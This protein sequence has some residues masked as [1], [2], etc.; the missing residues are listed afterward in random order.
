MENSID[1]M[2]Q[3]FYFTDISET[4]EL[5]VDTDD[6]EHIDG[7]SEP[8]IQR[9]P[10]ENEIKYDAEPVILTDRK[11]SRVDMMNLILAEIDARKIAGH[12]INTANWFY[13]NG[14]NQIA[15]NI[16]MI[17]GRIK[18]YRDKVAE[19]LSIDFINFEVT[20]E[21]I[22][23]TPATR[24]KYSSSTSTLLTPSVA[25]TRSMTY[26]ANMFMN[27]T[28]TAIATLKN[29]STQTRTEKI[30]DHRIAS[31]PCLVRSNLCNTS[32]C[33]TEML[34]GLNEDPKDPGGYFII[35]GNEWI[36]DN[37][38]NITTNSFHVYRNMH[39]NEITRGTFL[40]KPGDAFENS[41]QIILRYLNTGAITFELTKGKFDKIELPFYLI[42]R[43]LGITSDKKIVDHIVLG[44][45]NNDVITVQL[46]EIII[47]AFTTDDSRFGKLMQ[48]IDPNKIIQELALKL[49]EV[50]IN[51]ALKDDNMI[52]HL[53]INML[54]LLDKFIFPHI[55][56]TREFRIRKARFLGH[57]INKLLLVTLGIIEPTDRNSYAN[58]R[59]HSAGITLAKSFKTN[60]NL[61][62]VQPI[63]NN[64]KKEF[65]ST[66]FSQ[67]PL[68][69]S[70]K[71]SIKGDE[72]ERMM[73]H[74]IT[75]GD[76]TITIRQTE[77]VNRVSSQQMH[78][79]N[80]LN[81]SS[82]LNGVNTPG[83]S[84]SK[85]NEQADQMRRVQ[86]SYFGFIDMSQ[87]ADG[88]EK[89]GR[90]KQLACT[91]SISPPIKMYPLKDRLYHDPDIINI[92][93]IDP[94][95]ITY[96]K[97]AK[98][99]VN[100]DWIGCCKYAKQIVDKYRTH[101]RHGTIHRY[102]TIVWNPTIRE[103]YFWTDIGRLMRP[104]TIVYN[105]INDYIT[106][107]RSGEPIK[108]QQW[109]KLTKE[110]VNKLRNG[111]IDM[112]YLLNERI[113]EYIS[114]EEQ[115]NML[116]AQSIDYLRENEFNILMPYT[117][118]DIEQAMF[119]IVTLACPL[120]N[121]SSPAR[122]TMYTNHRKQSAS[123][124]ALNWDSLILKS[125]TL[126]WY[127]ENPPVSTIVNNITMPAGHTAIVAMGNFGNNQED[128]LIVNGSSIASGMFNAT[129]YD[130]EKIELDKNEVFGN[131]DEART[132]RR[133]SD[134]IYEYATDGGLIKAG[135][136][137]TNGVVLAIK[138]ATLSKPEG[139]YLYEDRSIVYSKQEAARVDRVI[140]VRDGDNNKIVKIVLASTRPL[141]VGDK[142]SSRSGNKGICSQIEQRINM[143]YTEDGLVP[144]ILCNTHS[145]PT[146]MAVN[147]MIEM[148][149]DLLGAHYGS[150]IDGTTFKE[151]DI[152]SA[153]KFLADV[154]IKYAGTRTMYSGTTGNFYNIPIF[155]A[156][157]GYQRLQ[158]Y[159]ID[160][161]YANNSGPIMP[162]TH[163]PREGKKKKGGLKFGEMEKDVQVA[164]GTM[165]AF[166]E[167]MYK[168]SDIQ[169]LPFCRK[170]NNY[171]IVNEYAN[172]YKCLHCK[173]LADIVYVQ[174]SH[175]SKVLNDEFVSMNANLQYYVANRQYD[176]GEDDI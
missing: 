137:V 67:V 98:V 6:S 105:N 21:N 134:A 79:K 93:D 126:Q 127:C 92:D 169:F 155:I 112:E 123:W 12:H 135:T 147:Q 65:A 11:V 106:K 10:Q 55:G 125:V 56:I 157:C 28:V 29:G 131:P 101:R 4:T 75:T 163:Q 139:N 146:R 154:G 22:Y 116:I 114:P 168:D 84:A 173:D 109:I 87:S 144:D 32:N 40:S 76:K 50:N 57:L 152:D 25:K 149:L 142:L 117:H 62:F 133:K 102:I 82:T 132:A 138:T 41:Y 73:T 148:L 91:T 70:V 13:S 143:P 71:A 164:H 167:K 122:T 174:A 66:P 170:C 46:R 74:S 49:T 19:D 37:L 97:M 156:P 176:I 86:P 172:I 83:S 108:F 77:I 17:E 31:I 60:Y 72:L 20:V 107:W 175:M 27:A 150:H 128:S 129:Y 69:E 95:T 30:I 58:K 130:Y 18:N 103:I 158:K 9:N 51:S 89:V 54:N 14:I 100:G 171:A 59:I 121:H 8:K 34:K 36:I 7:G 53:N 110:H 81:V 151:Q 5:D 23:L 35:K 140:Q 1:N 26:S 3:S 64:F 141:R 99:F 119:G 160:E 115:E 61:V 48:E 120:V 111:E 145:I 63:I 2:L 94:A 161:H 15:T 96:E 39:N 78:R 166:Y 113:I 44:V 52:K 104:L 43:I 136:I 162:I 42:F 153:I 68:A 16:F 33:T 124:Y 85:Q 88:G 165:Y 90:T 38:E 45:E 24:N 47:K 118:C 80:E 159:V